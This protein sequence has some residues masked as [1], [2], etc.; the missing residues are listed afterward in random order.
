MA[1]WTPDPALTFFHDSAATETPRGESA[2]LA[3]SGGWETLVAASAITQDVYFLEL[4]INNGASAGTIDQARISLSL[5]G[6]TTYL[7]Q[8]LLAWS[9]SPI[10][11]GGINY[12][13]PIFIPRG[14]TLSVIRDA[15]A[16]GCSVWAKLWGGPKRPTSFKVGSKITTYGFNSGAGTTITPGSVSDGAFV[17]LATATFDTFWV[18]AGLSINDTTMA[19]G[20]TVL[21]VGDGTNAYTPHFRFTTS[22]DEEIGLIASPG[23]CHIPRGAAIQARAKQGGT[24]NS[25]FTTMVYGVSG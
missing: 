17:S 16:N 3:M 6:G 18:Q 10:R 8:G 7:V 20:T 25:T 22:S 14:S 1:L 2:G 11:K 15:G 23:W 13:F 19:D 5:D 12:M 24:G 21:Q 4:C 9:S